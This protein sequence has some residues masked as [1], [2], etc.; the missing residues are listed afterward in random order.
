M[1]SRLQS[2]EDIGNRLKRDAAP[3]IPLYKVMKR[4]AAL[5]VVG[6]DLQKENILLTSGERKDKIPV[7]SG[8]EPKEAIHTPDPGQ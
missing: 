6:S 2:R 3:L 8:P 7:G 4:I 1:V 5:T